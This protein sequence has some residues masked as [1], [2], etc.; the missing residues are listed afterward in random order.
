MPDAAAT[1]PDGA[2][3]PVRALFYLGP[4]A[5]TPRLLVRALLIAAAVG[6]LSFLWGRLDIQDLHARAKALPAAAVVAVISLAP[7][8]GFPVSWL[9]LIAGV[10]FDFLG[11]MVVVAVTSVL[12]HVLGWALVRVLPARF[13]QRL[14]PWREKLRGAGH[15]DAT[16]L[17][18]LLP[19]MPY[20]V[21]LYLMPVLGT[22]FH[23]MFGLSALLHTAR[24]VVTILFGDISDDLTPPRVASLAAYYVVLFAVSALALH[25]LR[26]TLAMKTTDPARI[27]PAQITARAR[28][29]WQIAGSP[30]GRDLDFWLQAES[31]LKKERAQVAE[32][33]PAHPAETTAS[34]S[35]RSP[36]VP[37]RSR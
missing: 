28:S 18:C 5:V 24:A 26:R 21:Q 19:G 8:I 23:L 12:H 32:Q 31:E 11:G 2:A 3:P 33:A 22:P 25:R 6:A 10:R 20:T 4:L 37:R 17:C 13:F 27:D 1:F 36:N 9:H 29:L 34:S 15:R 35:D 14:D 30:P 16:L 7:L